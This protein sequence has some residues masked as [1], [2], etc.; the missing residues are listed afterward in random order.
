MTNKGKV[1]LAVVKNDQGQ[2]LMTRKVNSEKGKNGTSLTWVFPGG[3]LEEGETLQ[4]A[5]VREVLAETGFFVSAIEE[6][7]TRI[8]P[9]FSVEIHYFS[10]Q[11]ISHNQLRPI[12]EKY[13]IAEYKW[14]D[15]GDIKKLIT[16]DLDPGVAKYLGI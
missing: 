15:S 2:V 9:E 14:V 1:V 8:H 4:K 7:S 11:M 13:E 16:S 6:I 12:K 3:W 5:L 10:A